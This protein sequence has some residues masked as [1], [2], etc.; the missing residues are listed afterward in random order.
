MDYVVHGVTESDTTEQLLLRPYESSF[1]FCHI[2]LRQDLYK[3]VL[4]R[5]NTIDPDGKRCKR[6]KKKR[7]LRESPKMLSQ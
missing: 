4:E 1:W 7:H 6:E 3:M 5:E 2:V